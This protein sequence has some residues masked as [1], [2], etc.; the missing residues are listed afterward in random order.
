MLGHGRAGV[1]VPGEGHAVRETEA[2]HARQEPVALLPLP[3][4]G[5]PRSGVCGAQQ[6]QAVEQGV[7]VLLRSQPAQG[8]HTRGVRCA[9]GRGRGLRA[10]DPVGDHD[11]AAGVPPLPHHRRGCVRHGDRRVRAPQPARVQGGHRAGTTRTRVVEPGV[12]RDPVLRAD[13]QRHAP[14]ACVSRETGHAQP[15][16]DRGAHEVRVGQVGV[17]HRGAQGAH[18]VAQRGRRRRGRPDRARHPVRG[19]VAVRPVGGAV[20]PVRDPVRAVGSHARGAGRCPRAAGRGTRT[21][22][23]GEDGGTGGVQLIRQ[24]PGRAQHGQ[25]ESGDARAGH[26]QDVARHS[27][28]VR[29]RGD[30]Q[31]EGIEHQ[32]H[33]S[34]RS[35]AVQ[36]PWPPST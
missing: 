20:H 11:D 14:D 16:Q 15:P 2:F 26:V 10:V 4:Q 35:R 34:S 6:G 12:V 24:A 36:K 5:E 9:A 32:N 19:V 3:G 33:R 29:Y 8:Q 18:R 27:P 31:H 13:Q 17:H 21:E 1:H 25:P 7:Q 30:P 28:G 23:P 22:G